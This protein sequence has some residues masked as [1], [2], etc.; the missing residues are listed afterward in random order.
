[1]KV[2]VDATTEVGQRTARILLSESDVDFIG[3]W[4]DDT[5]TRGARSGPASSTS[6]FDVAV[7]DADDPSSSLAAHCSVEGIPLVLWSDGAAIPRGSTNAPVVVGA[8]VG[9][10]LAEVLRFHPTANASSEDSIRIAWTEPGR[11]LRR[12]EAIVFPDPVGTA[13][14]RERAK[15]RF[16]AH[17]DGLWGGA[18]IEL[19]GPAGRRIVGVADNASHLEALVLAATTLV[20]ADGGYPSAVS[21][22]ASA[23]EQ[24]L[25]KLIHV[26]LDFA[27]WRSAS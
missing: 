2:L 26:E 1:M 25:N 15:D 5:A 7:S 23:G 20:A 17:T 4:N 13:W 3:L 11:P 8:N 12:G 24:L 14:S 27:T 22:A 16:V 18:V 21:T 9:T 6:G 10:A 19:Q